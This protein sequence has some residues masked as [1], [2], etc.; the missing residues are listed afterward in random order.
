MNDDDNFIEDVMT[1]CHHWRMYKEFYRETYN[2]KNIHEKRSYIGKV[3]DEIYGGETSIGFYQ[4]VNSIIQNQRDGRNDEKTFYQLDYYK[5]LNRDEENDDSFSGF[6]ATAN[7][8]LGRY[9]IGTF[10]HDGVKTKF[11]GTEFSNRYIKEEM[12]EFLD[13]F[14]NNREYVNTVLD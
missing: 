6:F 2:D 5:Y 4:R 11:S 8:S 14:I 7:I 1:D 10:S 9:Y 3:C 12:K 13:S